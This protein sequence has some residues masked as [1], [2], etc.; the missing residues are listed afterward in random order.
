MLYFFRWPEEETTV[1]E[2][3]NMSKDEKEVTETDHS[4]KLNAE[5]ES[6]QLTV[7]KRPEEVY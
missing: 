1:D 4:N 5:K 3:E 2:L 7:G 6:C